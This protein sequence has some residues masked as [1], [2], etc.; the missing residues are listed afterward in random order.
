M[1]GKLR[2]AKGCQRCHSRISAGAILLDAGASGPVPVSKSAKGVFPLIAHSTASWG[3]H[4]GHAG[5]APV[6]GRLH[7]CRTDLSTGA[8]RHLRRQPPHPNSTG[9]GLWS[10]C[11]G[12]PS[13]AMGWPAVP[14]ECSGAVGGRCSGAHSQAPVLTPQLTYVSVPAGSDLRPPLIHFIHSV[15][16]QKKKST[17]SRRKTGWMGG[18]GVF[19]RH[20][21]HWR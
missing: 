1:P 2:D 15:V 13:G 7:R 17:D 9:A 4:R 16:T 10:R 8:K 6:P 20:Q 21:S 11:H 5:L 18:G 19:I 12:M 14:G 3:R